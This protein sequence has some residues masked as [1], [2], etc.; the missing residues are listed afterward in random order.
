MCLGS[1]S[2]TRLTVDAQDLQQIPA[3]VGESKNKQK[4]TFKFNMPVLGRLPHSHPIPARGFRE[5]ESDPWL[6]LAV[7]PTKMTTTAIFS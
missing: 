3:L 6:M 7:F 4:I 5:W 1:Y 2:T